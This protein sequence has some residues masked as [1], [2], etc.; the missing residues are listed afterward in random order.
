MG[1]SIGN[2]FNEAFEEVIE[3]PLKKIGRETKE[4]ITGTSKEDYRMVEQ[5]Q[6]TAEV[7]P[8][9]VPDEEIDTLMNATKKYQT[10]HKDGTDIA[11]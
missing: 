7:T 11:L 8:E 5:P 1:G 3:K 6:V 4:T 10:K 9:V 2:L